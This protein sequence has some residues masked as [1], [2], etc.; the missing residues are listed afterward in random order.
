MI[1]CE[2][3]IYMINIGVGTDFFGAVSRSNDTRVI[4]E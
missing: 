2:I 4:R 3:Y 1:P